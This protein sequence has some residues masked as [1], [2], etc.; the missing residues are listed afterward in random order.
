MKI[1]DKIN[2]KKVQF[3]FNEN[4]LE[5]LNVTIKGLQKTI[6]Y[7]EIRN[8]IE[9]H[10][11]SKSIMNTSSNIQSFFQYFL[12]NS[13]SFNDN[14]ERHQSKIGNSEIDLNREL[15]QSLCLSKKMKWYGSNMNRK[16]MKDIEFCS[17]VY[18]LFYDDSQLSKIFKVKEYSETGKFEFK[19]RK[20]IE[21]RINSISYD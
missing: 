13:T 20:K 3:D 10:F 8:D 16:K 11:R 6:I 1:V 15:V 17:F 4:G 19:L 18:H 9:E 2:G 14:V 5:F 7:N 21:R 12:N